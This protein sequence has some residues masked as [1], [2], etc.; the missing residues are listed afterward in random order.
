MKGSLLDYYSQMYN[1]ARRPGRAGIYTSP[2]DFFVPGYPVAS[3]RFQIFGLPDFVTD[4]PDED[5]DDTAEDVAK[6]IIEEEKYAEQGGGSWDNVYAPGNPNNRSFPYAWENDRNGPAGEPFMP[7]IDTNAALSW[8]DRLR[9]IGYGAAGMKGGLKGLL[10]GLGNPLN[11]PG[12]V[13]AAEALADQGYVDSANSL[14]SATQTLMSGTPTQK[15]EGFLNS[16]IPT[17]PMFSPNITN[18]MLHPTNTFRGLGML[19]TLGLPEEMVNQYAHYDQ[20]APE[21]GYIANPTGLS[22]LDFAESYRGLNMIGRDPRNPLNHALGLD[23]GNIGTLGKYGYTAP[24]T[25]DNGLYGIHH[26][27]LEGIANGAYS[28]D[29]PVAQAVARTADRME[30]ISATQDWA[31]LTLDGIT[32]LTYDKWRDQ[33]AGYDSGLVADAERKNYGFSTPA[34][35]GDIRSN[36]YN[37]GSPSGGGGGGNTNAGSGGMKSDNASNTPS[38]GSRNT[39]SYSHRSQRSSGGGGG[40]ASAAAGRSAGARQASGRG[41]PSGGYH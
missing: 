39:G 34:P 1:E 14:L 10:T 11:D 41:G 31:N 19:Q 25:I 18:E 16:L 9:G 36:K 12:V 23:Y 6:K 40:N 17:M 33:N 21:A 32:D 8:G 4:V 22:P 30:N 37:S 26:S 2:D 13:S 29:G 5:A 24:N 35:G 27:L 20:Y 15:K 3:Y 38:P 28:P 7:G